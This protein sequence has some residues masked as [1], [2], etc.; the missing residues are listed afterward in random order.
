[1]GSPLRPEPG[2]TAPVGR[3]RGLS[4]LAA[5]LVVLAVILAASDS[6]GSSSDAKKNTTQSTKATT[7]TEGAQPAAT[8]FTGTQ[9]AIDQYLKSQGIAYAGDCADAKLPQDK[10]KWCSTLVSGGE[11]SDTATYDL[12]PVGEKPQKRIT[13]KRHGQAVVLTPGYQVPVGEGNVGDPSQLTREQLEA[14]TF[15]L[16]NLRLDQA[17]GIGNGDADLPAGATTGNNTGGGGGGGGG[18][19]TGTTTPPPTVVTEPANAE[20]PPKGTITVTPNVDVGGEVVFQGS[21]CLP[22]EP[23]TVSFDGQQVGSISADTSGAFAG[24]LSIPKGT[25]PGAHLLTIQGSSCVLNATVNVAG[26]LAFTGSSSHTG[27]YVLGG[28]AAVVGGVILVLW[29]RRRRRGI[30]GLP[31]PSSA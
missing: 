10:G 14:N 4:T 7:T 3:F 2:Q 16:N 11:T 18:G 24:S 28:I 13:L 23:L 17:L 25:S 8:E 5:V 20:Y 15:I 1:M 22:N 19:G 31:P 21:G 26:A 12:G 27:T 30:R 29:S 9:A 6:G